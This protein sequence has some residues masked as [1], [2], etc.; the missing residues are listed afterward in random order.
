MTKTAAPKGG[1]AQSGG[2]MHTEAKDSSLMTA[3][4]VPLSSA[5]PSSPPPSIQ[6][7][8]VSPGQHL[9]AP[10]APKGWCRVGG[11]GNPGSSRSPLVPVRLAPG[12]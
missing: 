11:Q 5:V 3:R 6:Q 4:R 7:G 12:K 1:S 8:D 10:P 9:L 2:R